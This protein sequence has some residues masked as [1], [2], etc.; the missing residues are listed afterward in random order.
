MTTDQPIAHVKVAV[1]GLVAITAF[2]SWFYAFGVL[3]DPIIED[4]GWREGMLA[5]SFSAG[6]LIIAV[7]SI[8]GGRLLDR[9]GTTPLFVSAAFAGGGAMLGASWAENVWVFAALSALAMGAMGALGQYHITMTAA[10]R[11]SPR[12]PTKAITVLTIWGAFASPIYVPLTAWM[13]DDHGWR[14]TTRALALSGTAIFLLGAVVARIPGE[15]H[16]ENTRPSMRDVARATIDAPRARAFTIAV[17]LAGISLT[18]LLVYQV[19][20]MVAAGLPLGTASTIAAIR[21]LCQLTG[22][23]P[24]TPL[25]R[26]I[27]ARLTLVVALAAMAIGTLLLLFAG[28]ILIGLVFAVVA[29]FG[30]GAYSALQGIY[31]EELFDRATLGTT[32]GLLTFIHMFAGATGPLISGSLADLTGDREWAVVLAVSTAVMAVLILLRSGQTSRTPPEP[33]T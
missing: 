32:M 20:L 16:P 15:T 12:A 10:V 27:T 28:N 9:V 23:L 31:S 33:S 18:T 11:S 24:L 1:L 4:T 29:G 25:V 30:I 17:A 3:L 7:G 14:V 26:R 22:R 5:A 6:L 21:G 19:P 13:V 8:F 2:G